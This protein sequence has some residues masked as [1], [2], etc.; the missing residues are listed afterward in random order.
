MV[1][2][3]VVVELSELSE[4]YSYWEAPILLE[5]DKDLGVR[6]AELAGLDIDFDVVVF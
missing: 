4:V 6:T 1:W 2:A 5:E 3:Q